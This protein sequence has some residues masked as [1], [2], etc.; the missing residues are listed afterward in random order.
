[1]GPTIIN[2]G[3][4]IVDRQFGPSG[5]HLGGEAVVAVRAT[6]NGL[7]LVGLAEGALLGAAYATAGLRHP[8]LLG[9]APVFSL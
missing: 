1:M 5:E 7:V 3:R 8:V 9:F 6:V 4:I 2:Q